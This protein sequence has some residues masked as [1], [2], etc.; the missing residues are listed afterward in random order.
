M[1]PVLKILDKS[2]FFVSKLK[3]K[4]SLKCLVLKLDDINGR[5]NYCCFQKKA[6]HKS[7]S[8]AISRLLWKMKSQEESEDKKITKVLSPTPTTP[9][10]YN[11][12]LCMD[13][14]RAIINYSSLVGQNLLKVSVLGH[15]LFESLISLIALS[16]PAPLLS[17]FNQPFFLVSSIML[18]KI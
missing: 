10:N 4:N 11:I 7:S 18:L 12:L 14:F 16:T 2:I 5:L 1:F 6:I 17:T 9:D 8:F 13:L 15:V 3:K